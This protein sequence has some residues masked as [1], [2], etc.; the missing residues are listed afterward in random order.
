MESTSL[1]E[2][3]VCSSSAIKPD[4]HTLSTKLMSDQSNSFLGLAMVCFVLGHAE[5]V[6]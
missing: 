4:G 1:L 5:A 3:S 2:R 6:T